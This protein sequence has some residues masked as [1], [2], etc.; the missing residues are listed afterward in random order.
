[1]AAM[2]FEISAE[3]LSDAQA[4]L[5]EESEVGEKARLIVEYAERQGG[6]TL[7][8]WQLKKGPLFGTTN[9]CTMEWCARDLNLPLS[10]VIE[11]ND[12]TWAWVQAQA[13]PRQPSSR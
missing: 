4:L 1:M 13:K 7:S 2:R 10:R 12:R 3:T 9:M 8:Y 5:R 11:I 6:D